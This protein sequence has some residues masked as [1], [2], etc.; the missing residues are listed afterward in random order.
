MQEAENL[1]NQ[2]KV[3]LIIGEYESTEW[4]QK[5]AEFK[6]EPE[7]GK[8]CNICFEM[9]L[10]QVA[11]LA[12]QLHINKLPITN[13]V[14]SKDIAGSIVPKSCGALSATNSIV[15]KDYEALQEIYF[16]TTLSIS[17]HKNI[18][19]INSAGEKASQKYGIKFLARDWKKKNGYLKATQ[20]A[21]NL[22]LKRQNYCGCVYS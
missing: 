3:P 7:R 4:F 6:N 12:R 20:L 19:Q 22:H 15:R 17:P 10:D 11:A 2:M 13:S 18:N 1:C 21:Q 16:A 5:T 8:R 14:V 9:R